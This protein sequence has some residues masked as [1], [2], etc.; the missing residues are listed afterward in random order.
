[1][2]ERAG[3]SRRR[4]RRSRDGAQKRCC[5]LER[6]MGRHVALYYAELKM[7]LDDSKGRKGELKKIRDCFAKNELKLN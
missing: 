2:L 1:M 3:L 5:T 4:R 7:I 6:A